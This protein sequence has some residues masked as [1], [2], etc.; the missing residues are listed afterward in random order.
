[1]RSKKGE[2]LT[3]DDFEQTAT[4]VDQDPYE[5]A[6]SL[7][8]CYVSCPENADRS[9][10]GACL[11]TDG[12]TRPLHFAFVHPV[13]PT[14][15]QKMLYGPTLNEHV[16]VDVILEKLLSGLPQKPHVIF[17]NDDNLLA[18]RRITSC[19]V[20]VLSRRPNGNDGASMSLVVYNTGKRDDDSERV[21]RYVAQLEACSSIDL[22]QP[23]ERVLAALRE[24]L[25]ANQ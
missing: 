15:I 19:P 20:A 18:C 13:R 16:R 25:N 21:G 4:T 14:T 12:R 6:A 8:L 24:A 5:Q 3:M 1:V 17:V 9:F 2:S 22:T 7:L 10:T 23:F 11:L